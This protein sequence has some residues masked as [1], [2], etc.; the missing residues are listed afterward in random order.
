MGLF[1]PSQM[2]RDQVHTVAGWQALLQWTT[3]F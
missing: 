2:L 3:R 1:V